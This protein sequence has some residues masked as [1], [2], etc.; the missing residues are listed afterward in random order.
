M[1]SMT[2]ETT[3]TPIELTRL[4]NWEERWYA[5][6]GE[7]VGSQCIWGQDD[8][9]LMVGRNIEALTGEDHYS[10]HL[11][12]YST[13]LGAFKHLAGM[14]SKTPEEHM[15]KLFP[16]CPVARAKRGD[17]MSY[18]GCLGI[19][20]GAKTLFK[21]HVIDGNTEED[22]TV[23]FPTLECEQAWSIG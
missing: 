9:M 16:A 2:K 13:E 5:F 17:V 3:L 15:S 14:G 19:N 12:K 7:T 18:K 4:P 10:I 22:K 20:M 21:G 23:L 11:D 1:T 6:I 8:C